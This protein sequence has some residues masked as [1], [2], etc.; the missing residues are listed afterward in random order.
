MES[1]IRYK[2][3]ENKFYN[4]IE[5]WEFN[6]LLAI[7]SWHC[8]I[9]NWNITML[10]LRMKWNKFLRVKI[11]HHLC[12]LFKTWYICETSKQIFKI[13]ILLKKNILQICLFPTQKKIF[14]KQHVILQYKYNNFKTNMM[15]Q[16]KIFSRQ[17]VDSQQV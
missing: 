5:K 12:L 2:W 8:A 11:F 13:N 7:S 17:Q 10:P 3:T 1:L 16:M 9:K 15:T 6:L 4:M 14:S